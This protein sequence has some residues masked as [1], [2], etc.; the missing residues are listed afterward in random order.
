M[1]VALIADC[2]FG[3]KKSDIPFM[4]SQLRFYK[5]QFVPELKHANIKDIFILGD[6]FDTR[7]T[8]NVQTINVV[9]DLFKN[10]LKDFNISIIVGNH[11]MYMTTTTDINSLKILDILPNV[12]VYEKQTVLTIDSK[13]IL[14]QPWITDYS[15]Y[16]L[17]EHYDYAFMHADIIGFDQG[18]GRLSESG[19]VA[20]EI[21]KKVDAVYS[22]HYHNG[23]HREFEP[24]KCI[25]YLGAPYQL[26]RIDRDGIRGYHILD[27]KTGNRSLIEN[28]V[29][30]KFTRHVYPNADLN[31]VPGNVVDLDVPYEYADQT[32]KIST[33]VAKLDALK[34][35]YPVN[36]NILPSPDTEEEEFD[37]DNLNIISL[38]KNYL[39]QLETKVDKNDLYDNFIE[40]YNI[41]KEQA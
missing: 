22:G 5:E 6:V 32:K 13:T 7:Q 30:M 24:G 3:I 21:L 34:P 28:K 29:S 16:I 40:L 41:Y 15:T 18:G 26:T 20:K 31:I 8:I 14:L 19:L 36:I 25:T 39:D 38:F 27:I 9:I 12:T 35:A 1:K 37:T 23:V 33:Y 4:E 11:D 10:I 17:T 2:H